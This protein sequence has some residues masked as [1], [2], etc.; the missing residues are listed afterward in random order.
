[1]STYFPI[2]TATACQLKWTWS[3]IRLYNGTTSS[4]HRVDGDRITPDT[5]NSFHNTAKKISDRKLMLDGQWPSGGCEY[6]KDIE[7]AGG[8]SDRMF[9]LQI[10]DQTPPELEVDIN[11]TTVTPRIVE[12][13][14]DNVCNMSCLYCWDGFSSKIQQE[15]TRF[16]RFEQQGVV[17]DNRSQSNPVQDL[18]TE[19]LWTWLKSNSQHVRRLHVLGGEPLVQPQLDQCLDLLA[20]NPCQLELNVISNLKSSPERL[21]HIL[22]RVEQLLLANKIKRFDLTASIDC[23]GPEQEYVR[24][25]MDLD[26]W[27][28]NFEILTRTPFVTLNINQTLCGLTVKTIPDLLKYI[29]GLRHTREIGHY[30]STVVMTHDFLHPGIFGPEF[31]SRDFDEIMQHMPDHTWQQKQARQYM[32]GIMKQINSCDRNDVEIRKLGTFLD[33][34]D[35][36]RDLNWRATFPWLSRE[37]DHVV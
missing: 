17:I 3:T 11:A 1:M 22:D 33:E 4:C 21:T 13:Y 10:P 2:K 8:S 12:V 9:H 19:S 6:C 29:N 5:F 7:A 18:L 25:G 16:G 26:Q 36:R 34:I 28:T 23:W 37:V 27:K 15:N 32:Q 20:D 24:F 30:F 31:F 35:R 14:F